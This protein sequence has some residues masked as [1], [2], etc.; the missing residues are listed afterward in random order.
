VISSL[1]QIAS[2]IFSFSVTEF[3]DMVAQRSNARSVAINTR[4]CVRSD[5]L[6]GKTDSTH[7]AKSFVG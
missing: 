1:K 7:S 3:R 5:S 6:Q 4:H 2:E